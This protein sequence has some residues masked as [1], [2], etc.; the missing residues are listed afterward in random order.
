MKE[1]LRPKRNKICYEIWEKY[2]NEITMEELSEILNINLKSLY[3]ILAEHKKRSGRIP[4]KRGW[5]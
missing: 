3:R 5:Q 4:K 1:A 2:K